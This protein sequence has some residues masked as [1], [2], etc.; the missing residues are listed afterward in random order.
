ML[1]GKHDRAG[2][3]HADLAAQGD[4]ICFGVEDIFAIDQN[5]PGHRL[6]LGQVIQAIETTQQCGFTAASRTEQDRDG[7][8]RD[9]QADIAQRFGAVGVL[10]GEVFDNDLVHVY[11]CLLCSR[12]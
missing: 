4:Y 11:H 1:I 3:D 9:I 10:Q 7:V 2:K 8:L 6:D 12:P 5:A